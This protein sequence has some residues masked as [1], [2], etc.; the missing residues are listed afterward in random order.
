METEILVLKELDPENNDKIYAIYKYGS[1]VYGTIH[2][3]SDYDFIV[4]A[5]KEFI[6][7]TSIPH[8]DINTCSLEDF[9][10]NL[11]NNEIWA[12]ECVF[13]TPIYSKHKFNVVIDIQKL[14]VAVSRNSS[15]TFN[16]AKKK[17]LS[18]YDKDGELIRGK[19]ALFHSLRVLVFG[20]QI[21]KHQKIIDYQEANHYFT[22]IMH[23]YSD[24]WEDYIYL[25]LKYNALMTTFRK[26][27]PK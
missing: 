7:N 21:A 19:K 5:D 24:K 4:V 10:C 11:D 17:F 23:N 12:L 26:L 27:A 20:I 15:Q 2:E 1:R 9:Q 8:S 25:K 3:K 6:T 13:S 18:P 14:R 22:E 16:K